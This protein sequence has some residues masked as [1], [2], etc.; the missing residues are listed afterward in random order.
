MNKQNSTLKRAMIEALE[1]SLGIVTTACK[2]VGIDRGSHYNW[3][4]DDEQYK[5]EVES[6]ED[7]AIDFA[8]SQLH[9]QIKDGIPTSTIFYLKTKAKKRGYVERTEVHQETTIKSLDINIIDEGIAL[10]KSEKDI[11]K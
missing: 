6:I 3:M 9:K 5:S 2:S 10:S 11:E 8:E 1:K 4:K 7:I